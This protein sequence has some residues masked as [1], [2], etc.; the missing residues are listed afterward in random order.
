MDLKPIELGFWNDTF[1]K[2]KAILETNIA[3]QQVRGAIATS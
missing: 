2:K 3:Q 1:F